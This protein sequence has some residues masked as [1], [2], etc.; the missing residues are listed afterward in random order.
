MQFIHSFLIAYPMQGRGD[1]GPHPA[2][3]DKGRVQT[4]QVASSSQGCY[5]NFLNKL[6]YTQCHY[7]DK[8]YLDFLMLNE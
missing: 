1:A 3:L 7:S 4:E 6:T 2:S 8:R 5:L